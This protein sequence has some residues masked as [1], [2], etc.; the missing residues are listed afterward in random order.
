M[1]VVDVINVCFP[2]YVCGTQQQ[3]LIYLLIYFY[4]SCFAD[5]CEP[6]REDGVEESTEVQILFPSE[7]HLWHARNI[8]LEMAGL[9]D[10]LSLQ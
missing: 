10:C 9:C 3:Y 5:F 1:A 8:V 6:F 7:T 2:C 4:F